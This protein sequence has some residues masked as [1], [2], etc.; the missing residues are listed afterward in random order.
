MTRTK[1]WGVRCAA[2]IPTGTFVC[3]YVGELVHEAAVGEL[4]DDHYL[5]SLDYFMHLFKVGIG[6]GRGQRRMRQLGNPGSGRGVQ[7]ARKLSAP[8]GSRQQG[9][10]YWDGLL[11]LVLVGEA[12]LG[13]T[14]QNPALSHTNKP[15]SRPSSRPV[16]T[17][18]PGVPPTSLETLLSPCMHLP[19]APSARL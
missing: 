10:R 7:G 6:Q 4:G 17:S 11:W 9:S 14:L 8:G 19:G 16:C 12:D 15:P 2:D 3:S 1:G 18:L 5:F 13:F